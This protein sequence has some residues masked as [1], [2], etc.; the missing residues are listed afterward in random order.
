MAKIYHANI[1]LGQENS[2]DFL[3]NIL[4]KNLDFKTQGNPD[5]LLMEVESFGID[6]ARSLGKWAIGKALLGEIKVC[7]I[8]TKSI[9]PEAQNALLK[10]LE[11]PTL[12]TYF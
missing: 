9:T 5:F 2:T 4:E 12:G 11:E 8:K 10:I 3:F 1:I 6:D 7:F